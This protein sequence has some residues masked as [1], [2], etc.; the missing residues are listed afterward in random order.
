MTIFLI[1]GFG[2]MLVAPSLRRSKQKSLARAAGAAAIVALAFFGLAHSDPRNGLASIETDRRFYLL[3]LACELPV[4]AL[5]LILLR[6]SQW[7]FWLGW[8]INLALALYL[9]A[10][11]LWLEF[12]WHW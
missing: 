9:T 5:A 2:L 10:I 1:L 3:F 6:P 8:S 4:L 7:A 11:L 12:F